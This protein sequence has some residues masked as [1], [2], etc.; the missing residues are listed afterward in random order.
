MENPI[1]MDDGTGYKLGNLQ[2]TALAAESSGVLSP[3]LLVK[4]L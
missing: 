1:K 3:A 4:W 2:I